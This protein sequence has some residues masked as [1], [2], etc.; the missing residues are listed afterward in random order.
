MIDMDDLD[1]LSNSDRS[2]DGDINNITNNI[3]S[4]GKLKL[5]TYILV[6]P[7]KNNSNPVK[8]KNS[9]C[10]QCIHTYDS[11]VPGKE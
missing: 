5:L 2:M 9:T 8:D 3:K 11:V 1:K 7:K 4:I 6:E 10:D